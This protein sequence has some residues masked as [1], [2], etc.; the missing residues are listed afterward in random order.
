MVL[1]SWRGMA[2]GFMA[3]ALTLTGVAAAAAASQTVTG[4]WEGSYVCGQGITGLTLTVARQ[5]GA[6]FSGTFHFY[7]LPGH[8]AAKEGCFGV[9]GHFVTD[10]RIFV[11]AAAW[12]TRPQDYVSVDLDGQIDPAG[13][14]LKGRVKM[15]AGY[16]PLCST[17][18]LTLAAGP[19]VTPPPC[20]T[21]KSADLGAP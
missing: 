2:A 5:S 21:T 14:T 20:Q 9:T 6:T 17:F 11:G 13:R 8:P 3:A 4:N 7:P 18:D 15:P 1:R 12:I 10:R 19:P 16:P